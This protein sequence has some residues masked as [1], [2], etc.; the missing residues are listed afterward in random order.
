MIIGP[1][2]SFSVCLVFVGVLFLCYS[3]LC[4]FLECWLSAGSFTDL[5]VMFKRDY[6]LMLEARRGG[7]QGMKILAIHKET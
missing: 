3:F 1:G 5:L 2:T 7:R 6:W 4:I